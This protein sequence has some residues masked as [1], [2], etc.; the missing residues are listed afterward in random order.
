MHRSLTHS[1]VIFAVI[2]LPILALVHRNKK[3]TSLA[4]VGAVGV[5]THLMLDLFGDFTPLFWPLFDQSIKVS[6]AIDIHIG[7][8][9][10]FTESFR[11]LTE[12]TSF[13]PFVYF[14]EPMLTAPGA[15]V[16]AVLL[17]PILIKDLRP[18]KRG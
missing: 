13:A 11:V 5:I 3:L 15:G 9:P 4:L 2:I 6:T 12:P 18:K 16:S 7:S 17:I 1:I 8:Q 14:D 10:V